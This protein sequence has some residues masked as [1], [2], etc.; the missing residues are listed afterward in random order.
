MYYRQKRKIFNLYGKSFI[1]ASK[2]RRARKIENRK[3]KRR[4]EKGIFMH[5][6]SNGVASKTDKNCW[7]L[8]GEI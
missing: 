6:L 1:E 2:A 5:R 4:E 7:Q 8:N 3:E